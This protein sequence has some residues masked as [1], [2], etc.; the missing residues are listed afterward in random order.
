MPAGTRTRARA[1]PMR[2]SPRV[3]PTE[4]QERI[5]DGDGGVEADPVWDPAPTR[6]Y[7]H[8]ATLLDMLDVIDGTNVNDRLPPTNAEVDRVV[9]SSSSSSSTSTSTSPAQHTH[10]QMVDGSRRYTAA[11]KGKGRAPPAETITISDNEEGDGDDEAIV[12]T[13]VKR[14]IHEVE[15]EDVVDGGQTE[16]PG[17]V[18][19]DGEGEEEEHRLGEFSEWMFKGVGWCIGGG[20]AYDKLVLSAFANRL[21][22]S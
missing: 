19:R 16:A 8:G 21:R 22:P 13:G 14:K 3:R 17:E 12:V 7:D 15:D 11:E 20:G 9:P 18:E 10:T 2:R 1:I 6:R 5:P 4:E